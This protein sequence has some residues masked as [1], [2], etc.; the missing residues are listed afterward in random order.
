MGTFVSVT[1]EREETARA[2]LPLVN[3]LEGDISHRIPTSFVARLNAGETVTLSEE[4][5]EVLRLALSVREATEGAFT[6]FAYPLTSLWQF[7]HAPAVPDAEAITAALETVNASSLQFAGNEAFLTGALDLGAV[8]KGL[9]AD[10]LAAAL[11]ARGESGLITVGGSIAAV[12]GKNGEPWR[13]GVRDPFDGGKTVGTLLLR[14]AFVSTSGSYEKSFTENGVLYHHILDPHTGMPVQN[15]LLSVTVVAENGALSDILSTAAF[16]V[17]ME[18]GAAL[19]EAYGAHA[20]FITED[21]GLYATE[22][23]RALFISTAGEVTA[24]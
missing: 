8:G 3:D 15:G 6:P 12:G 5:Q 4:E 13:V 22:G 14:D 10:R 17:G 7:D 16:A 11:M 9:A 2:L 24:L 1:A 20:L 19:C 21:G 18:R 23:M